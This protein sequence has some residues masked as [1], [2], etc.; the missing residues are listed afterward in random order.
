[1]WIR[2]YNLVLGSF[3]AAQVQGIGFG[4]PSTMIATFVRFGSESLYTYIP[5]VLGGSWVVISGVICRVTIV[6]SPT[7]FGD[8]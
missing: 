6:I 2:V 1:M 4:E 3:K 5:A 7:V 8:L